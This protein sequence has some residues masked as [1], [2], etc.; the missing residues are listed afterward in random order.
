MQ[1]ACV[2]TLSIP[3][4]SNVMKNLANLIEDAARNSAPVLLRGETG[5]GRGYVAEQIHAASGRN[6]SFVS[7]D[8]SE[9]PPARVEHDLFGSDVASDA[10]RQPGAVEKARGGTLLIE[11]IGDLPE[12][13][14]R[15][16]VAALAAAD[17]RLVATSSRDLGADFSQEL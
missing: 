9:A 15:R 8:A 17:V 14:Q 11:E 7:Y 3:T 10:N 4:T 5:V 13:A 1:S 6:G 16:L 12:G 2:N